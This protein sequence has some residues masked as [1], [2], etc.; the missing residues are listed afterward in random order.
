MDQ[1]EPVNLTGN[2]EDKKAV[3]SFSIENILGLSDKN[4]ESKDLERRRE[5]FNGF[6]A[7]RM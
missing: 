1:C 4:V 2:H 3:C 7:Q 6:S 5:Y